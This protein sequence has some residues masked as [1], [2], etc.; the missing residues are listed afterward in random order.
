MTEHIHSSCQITFEACIQMCVKHASVSTYWGAQV[1]TI[2]CR[3]CYVK[4]PRKPIPLPH[5]PDISEV[6]SLRVVY[7]SV[8]AGRNH[9]QIIISQQ[10][11]QRV[12]KFTQTIS[13]KRPQV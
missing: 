11:W 5:H 8:T 13:S 1:N 12:E 4:F 6:M 2:A 3:S 7:K 9:Q 10:S